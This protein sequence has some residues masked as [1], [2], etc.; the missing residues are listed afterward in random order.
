MLIAP[1]SLKEQNHEACCISRVDVSVI[2]VHIHRSLVG[3]PCEIVCS[4]SRHYLVEQRSG[5]S[6][7]HPTGVPLAGPT[8]LGTIPTTETVPEGQVEV[9][10]S[11]ENIKPNFGR[12]RYMPVAPANYGLGGE[13]SVLPIY[14]RD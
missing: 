12:V 2:C 8:G 6:C 13:K 1:N 10:L 5:Q 3:S 9:G 14:V 11:F 7:A 4:C